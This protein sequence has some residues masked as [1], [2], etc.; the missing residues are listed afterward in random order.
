MHPIYICLPA[1]LDLS[2]VVAHAGA[3]PTPVPHWVVLLV[4]VVGL[5]V[6]IGGGVLA[7]ERLLARLPGR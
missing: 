4:G 7:V 3:R 2:S 5:W 1:V 6:V